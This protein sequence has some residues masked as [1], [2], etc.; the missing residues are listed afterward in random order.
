MI[1]IC[2][3]IYNH[4]VLPLV[5]SL[6]RQ[7]ANLRDEGDIEIVCID[8]HSSEPFLSQNS[9]IRDIATYIPLD[10]NIGRARI[11]NLFLQHSKGEWLLF[12][13]NDSLVPD[14]F[15]K[16][17]SSHL[18][19]TADVIVGGRIYDR[20][21]DD[22]QH[23]LR[24]LYGTQVESRS[25]VDRC[26]HPYK[27]FMTNNFLIRRSIFEKVQFDTRLGQYGH[28]DTLFGYRLQ[29]NNIP[30][31]HIENPVVNGDVEN[32]DEFLRKTIEGISSLVTIYRFMSDDRMFLHTV[33]LL[34]TYTKLRSLSLHPLVYCIFKRRKNTLERRFLSGEDISIRRFNFYKLGLFIQQMHYSKNK[35]T[36]NI[37]QKI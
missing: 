25:A 30:I 36:T 1:S 24:Y 12:L 21:D 16:T 18:A 13:D 29:Q 26:K 33:R 5:Q 15:L 6:S 3:P 34:D 19:G 7:I 31:L 37:N 17:Y 10:N 35:E 32:N 20:R 28:E 8:D 11:R 14:N 4:P 22:R 27:S 9:P 23:R 2:I